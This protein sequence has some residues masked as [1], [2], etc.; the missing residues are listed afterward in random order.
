MSKTLPD[1]ILEGSITINSVDAFNSILRLFPAMPE[2]IRMQADLL[3]GRNHREAAASHYDQA[4]R[5]FL[6]SGK[7]LQAIVAKVLEW[8]IIRPS[9]QSMLKFHLAVEV[10]A[11]VESP[12][13]RFLQGLVPQER[14]AVFAQFERF[15][16]S[17]GQ[18]VKKPGDPENS[19]YLIVSGKLKESL[20]QTVDQKPGIRRE[21]NRLLTDGDLF[22][23][24][25]PLHEAAL[26]KSF[27]DA[28][29]RSELVSIPK[30]RLIQICWKYPKV[31][32]GVIRLC[33]LRAET[34]SE[35]LSDLAR[36]GERYPV[37]AAMSVQIMPR[38]EKEKSI[39]LNGYTQDLSVSGMSF[40]VETDC[41]DG[42]PDL[43]A[44]AL[45]IAERKASVTLAAK[46][47]SITITGQVI[48]CRRAVVNGNRTLVLGIQF[49][50]IPPRLRGAFFSIAGY[51]DHFRYRLSA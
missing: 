13:D 43:S 29:A 27:V 6:C 32:Q 45:D 2:L 19:L 24:I 36:K 47:I 44:M 25:Y 15:W 4:A 31:E 41:L 33:R 3:A 26:S 18:A 39:V 50:E 46:E 23:E 17:A 49:A 38:N 16:V 10:A 21:S 7:L 35:S 37:P 9:R 28:V 20:F 12:L 30:R 48:R 22:G 42:S 5:L 40:I 11:H 1:F 14:M 8:R 51:T 34:R